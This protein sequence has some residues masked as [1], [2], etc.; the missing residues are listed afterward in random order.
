M[1]LIIIAIIAFMF[2][3][4]SNVLALYFKKDSKTANSV[5][6]FTAWE[7]SKSD[8]EIHNFTTYLVDWV[9]GTKLIFLAL[10]TVIIIF[11]TPMMHFWALWAL[12]ISIASFY[13]K[14]YPLAKKMDKED[15]VTPKGYSRTLGA[16]ITVF[17]IV[18]LSVAI[19]TVIQ[20]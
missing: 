14:L 17:I 10:L 18:F 8:P 13:W 9:A 5:G 2:L 15:Q 3:E 11:G 12:M 4:V 7:K 6:V 16:M 1:S 20:M 19:Y